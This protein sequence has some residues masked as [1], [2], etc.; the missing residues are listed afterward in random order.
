MGR[1][2]SEEDL[3]GMTEAKQI[4]DVLILPVNAFGSGQGHSQS[5]P[6]GNEEELLSHHFHGW[7]GWKSDFS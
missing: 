1:Q 5:K 6:F 4:G 3:K 7:V 2:V